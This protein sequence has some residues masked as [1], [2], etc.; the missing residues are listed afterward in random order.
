MHPSSYGLPCALLE[1]E[2]EGAVA[3]VAAF[4]GQLLGNDRKSGC[5]GLAIA[6]DEVADAKVIDISIVG[7]ALTREKLA[8]IRT[9]GAYRLSQLL[10]GQVV[11]QVK[12]CVQAVLLQQLFDIGRK[13][14]RFRGE[15]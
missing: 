10:Q 15:G 7:D 11:Q 6:T 5:G 9:I 2:A 3:V 4:V 1:S 13:I 14:E 8:E 12:F